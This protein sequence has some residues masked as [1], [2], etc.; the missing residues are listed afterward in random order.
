MTAMNPTKPTWLTSAELT[1]LAH[2]ENGAMSW[3]VAGLLGLG[4]EASNA[5]HL[6]QAASSLQARSMLATGPTGFTVS[7]DLATV[8]EVLAAPTS[9]AFISMM[10]GGHVRILW[11][12]GKQNRLLTLRPIAPGMFEPIVATGALARVAAGLA[13]GFL[14][15]PGPR[16]V[17]GSKLSGSA[18]AHGAETIS[19]RW[20][21]DATLVLT[22]SIDDSVASEPVSSCDAVRHAFQDFFSAA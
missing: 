10:E 5:D 16:L 6:R 20:E 3:L 4:H 7:P 1:W 19:A 18:S 22:R 15:S 11:L 8:A 12:F 13:E 9:G 14:G 21:P 2:I 17:T